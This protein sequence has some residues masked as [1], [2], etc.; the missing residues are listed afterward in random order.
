VLALLEDTA[1]EA[2]FAQP[3]SDGHDVTYGYGIVDPAAALRSAL[4]VEEE[5][6]PE[7]KADAGA[8]D[9][10]GKAEE[11]GGCAVAGGGPDTLSLA[12]IALSIWMLRRRRSQS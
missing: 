2:P 4:G 5:P 9:G 7:D 6:E 3:G 8:S 10:G 1:R 12:G 11:S